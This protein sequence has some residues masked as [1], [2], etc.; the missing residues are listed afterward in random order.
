MGLT[1]LYN[2]KQPFRGLVGPSYRIALILA[3]Q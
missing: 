2:T 1:S 3:E